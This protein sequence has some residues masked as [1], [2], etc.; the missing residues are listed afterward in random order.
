MNNNDH[1]LLIELSTKMDRTIGDIKDLA[2]SVLDNTVKLQECKLDKEVYSQWLT[3]FYK[4]Y[5]RDSEEIKNSIVQSIDGLKD[6]TKSILEDHEQRIRRI[7]KW[8]WVA[9]GGLA[10]LQIII[11]IIK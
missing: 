8:M 3:G 2:K 4:D 10:L 5:N 7:E 11:G 9:I 1:D 6:Y